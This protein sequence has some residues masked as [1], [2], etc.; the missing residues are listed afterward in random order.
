[1]DIAAALEHLRD[2]RWG[3]VETR[4]QFEFVLGA[5]AEEVEAMLKALP[6]T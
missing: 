3:M 1:M 2:Q 4:D 5:V 6:S